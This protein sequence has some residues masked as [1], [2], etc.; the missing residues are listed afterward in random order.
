MPPVNWSSFIGI[1][2]IFYW[3]IG[4]NLKNIVWLCDLINK[5]AVTIDSCLSH[6]TTSLCGGPFLDVIDINWME[7]F[8]EPRQAGGPGRGVSGVGRLAYRD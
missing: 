6:V 1:L 4:L 8:E 2:V 7:D 3:Y 5:S